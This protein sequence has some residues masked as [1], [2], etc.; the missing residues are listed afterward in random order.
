MTADELIALN[1]QIA[2]MAKAGLP[3]DQGLAGLAREMGHGRLRTVTAGIAADLQSGTPLPEAVERR[4][5]D[6]PPFYAH[7][8]NAGIRTGR[9]PEVLAT[10]TAY[11]RTVA[12]TTAVVVESLFYPT[13]VL[14]FAAFLIGGLIV[15]VIPVFDTIYHDFG[16]K[17]PPVTE[18]VLEIGR[19]PIPVI[20]V[21]AGIALGL[22]TAWLAL[23]STEH[24]RQLIARLVYGVPVIGTLIRAARLAAFADLLAILV[25][26]EMPLPQAVR[27]AG[28]ASSDPLMAGRIGVVQ[29]RLED[30]SAFGAAIRGLG[31]VPEWVA[32]MAGAGELRGTLAPALRQ[33]A[34]V[35]R[36][37]VES[38]ASM[39]RTVLPAFLIIFTAGIPVAIFV[40]AVMPPL[41]RLLEGLSK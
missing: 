25:E 6:L 32:W 33:I 22:F 17:L 15:G 28:D 36:R 23:R 14:A 21:P 16:M 24:G 26:Q 38:R 18:F 11:A 39:L 30:G 12:S 4:R 7:L 9:L 13:V 3:L 40:L 29:D 10:L 1:D 31:L 5:A 2:G 37:Q 8:V 41:F 35:Y 34:S 20:V 19:H 27:L